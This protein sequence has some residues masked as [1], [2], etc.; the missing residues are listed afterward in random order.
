MLFK[1][2][3]ED[4]TDF[5]AVRANPLR[6]FGLIYILLIVVIIWGG[7]FYIHSMNVMSG[8]E[9]KPLLPDT[10]Q[11]KTDIAPKQAMQLP[12]TDVNEASKPAPQA[13]ARGK[14]IFSSSCASCHGAA[15]RGDGVAGANLNPKPRNFTQE[16]GWTN[17]RKIT[18]IYKTLEEGVPGTAMVPYEFLPPADKFALAHFIRSLAPNAPETT[19]QELADADAK[20]S[21]SKGRNQAAQVPVKQAVKMILSERQPAIDRLVEAKKRLIA[22]D[23]NDPSRKAFERITSDRDRALYALLTSQPWRSDIRE[24]KMLI[25]S[26]APSNGFK[27]Q[28]LTLTAAELG[29]LHSYLVSIT[30]GPTPGAM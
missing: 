28:A 5:K 25:A 3:Y 17:G 30:S 6:W 19:P 8:A 15:G 1:D 16:S 24:F 23:A 13:I 10:T 14:E 11:L 27:A 12:G 29:A 7:M 2:K 21:I 26:G 4:E 18:D 22:T 20:Y 9:I